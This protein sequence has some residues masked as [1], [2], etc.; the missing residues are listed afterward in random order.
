[1]QGI[2]GVLVVVGI[3]EVGNLSFDF[4]PRSLFVL[5]AAQ[6]TRQQIAVASA[7]K[8]MTQWGAGAWWAG[9]CVVVCGI[10]GLFSNSR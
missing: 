5:I 10:L 2:G 1:M 8:S 7:A 6:I 3:V 4:A 9:V